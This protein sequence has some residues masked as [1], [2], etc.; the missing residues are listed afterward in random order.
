MVVVEADESPRELAG[1]SIARSL[2]RT[3]AAL[4]GRVTSPASRGTNA[5]LMA[6]A[7]LIRGPQ[8]VLELLSAGPR[9]ASISQHD[10]VERLDPR[11]AKIFE[12]V[13]AGSDTPGKL[14][15]AAD[16]AGEVL[17]A[18]SELEL[19]GLLARGDGGRYVPRVSLTIGSKGPRGLRGT[20]RDSINPLDRYLGESA[21]GGNREKR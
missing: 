21:R 9:S 20:E 13:G 7:R 19:L 10:T 15:G 5:L 1:A 8:D 6:G 16:D 2:G 11:L 3:V 14:V 18:L 12:S 17:L 4:P